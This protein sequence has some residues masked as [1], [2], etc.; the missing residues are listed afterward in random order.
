MTN[1][2]DKHAQQPV[3][4]PVR[5]EGRIETFPETRTIPAHWDVSGLMASKPAPKTEEVHAPGKLETFPETRTIPAH[6]DLS[7][8]YK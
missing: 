5:E 2:T 6:W 4:E 8:L 1:Q 7:E 3:D